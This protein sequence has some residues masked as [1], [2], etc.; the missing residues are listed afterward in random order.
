[1]STTLIRESRQI[2][3][4]ATLKRQAI[5]D[6][7]DAAGPCSVLEVA[8]LLECRPDRLY[9]HFRRL[10]AAGLLKGRRRRLGDGRPSVIYALQKPRP[11]L[12][13]D[14]HDRANV[15]AVNAVVAGMMREASRTFRRA[16][17]PGTVATGERREIWAGRRVGW[18][19]AAERES[20]NRLVHKLMALLTARP[21][22]TRSA[23][24]YAFVF[25]FSPL[26]APRK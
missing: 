9:Y 22:P 8:D 5:V 20:L 2:R 13:Y 19:T 3:T 23:K 26:S 10:V 14:P 18:L 1:M 16:F 25:S 12:L 24:L 4:L 21:H 17:G 11:Q 15:A 7:L 6:I